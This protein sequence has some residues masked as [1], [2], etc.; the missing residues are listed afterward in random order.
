[1]QVPQVEVGG[2]GENGAVKVGGG[3][4]VEELLSGC[5][6]L[7]RKLKDEKQRIRNFI[8]RQKEEHERRIQKMED[9][10]LNSQEEEEAEE[11]VEEEDEEVDMF[12]EDAAAAATGGVAQKRKVPVFGAAGST[13]RRKVVCGGTLNPLDHVTTLSDNWDDSEGYYLARIGELMDGRY[14]VKFTCGKGV[15][16]TV[17]RCFDSTNNRHVAVK[18]I[19]ANDMMRR[20]AEKE[21]DILRKL[22][23]T[24][25]DDRRHIIRLVRHFTYRGHLCMVFEW[26]W[27][28]L[29]MAL[30]KYGGGNGLNAMA[31][32]SYTK[33]LFAALKH[34]KKNSIIHADLKPDN[35]LLGE[36]FNTLKVCDLGSASDVDDNDVTAYLVSRFY[37][38]PEI[39]VGNKYDTQIDVWSAATTVYE[40]ATG[41]VLF[42]GRNNND[43]LKHIMEVK[44]KLPNKMIRAGQLSSN[45]FDDNLDFLYTD[46]D[47]YTK[48]D[49]LRVFHDLRPTRNITEMLLSKQPWTLTGSSS[50]VSSNTATAAAKAQLVRRKTRQLG[51]L[52]EKCLALDPAKRMTPEEAMAHPF[53]REPLIATTTPTATAAATAG[54]N[55]TAATATTSPTAAA[56]NGRR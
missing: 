16:S 30:K 26:M 44:G 18:V 12:S 56:V 41:E 48:K 29:R 8:I 21:M 6:E 42:Q 53:I 47:S 17:V 34:M 49:V 1:M 4:K 45:H 7:Q 52:L 22:N 36:K 2:G 40:L 3:L 14:E 23:T 13:K 20:A 15:F 37:R 35:I 55:S 50:S 10:Q 24:D 31:I 51:D 9:E 28:N 32:H 27:G 19:R 46:K 54:T 33:Q 25:K 5:E 43:M 38:A 11:E 39:I